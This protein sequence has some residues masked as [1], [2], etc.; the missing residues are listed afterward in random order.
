MVLSTLVVNTIIAKGPIIFVSLAQADTGEIDVW[1]SA[2][3]YGKQDTNMN[4]YADDSFYLNYTQVTMLYGN[5]YNLA[6]RMHIASAEPQIGIKADTYFLDFER[7]KDIN[8]GVFWQF[9]DLKDD[10]CVLM[11]ADLAYG[12][13]VGD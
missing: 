4:N 5:T 8:L 1:Y 6:P 3:T 9:N 11:N 13:K 2:K 7:E 10:E 12:L